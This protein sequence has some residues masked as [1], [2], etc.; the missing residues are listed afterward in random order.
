ME[1][2]KFC[3]YNHSCACGARATDPHGVLDDP[4]HFIFDFFIRVGW[5]RSVPVGDTKRG[6]YIPERVEFLDVYGVCNSEGCST[7]SQEFQYLFYVSNLLR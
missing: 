1:E 4:S 5:T 6:P 7:T 3:R 2:N